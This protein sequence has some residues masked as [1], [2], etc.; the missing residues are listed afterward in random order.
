MIPQ[1]LF[2]T[3]DH[4]TERDRTGLGTVTVT[5]IPSTVPRSG[6]H[7]NL[8]DLVEKWASCYWASRRIARIGNCLGSSIGTGSILGSA[9][10]NVGSNFSWARMK[11][12]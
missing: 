8:I 7:P 4:I 11:I 10:P 9:R 5:I 6:R 12:W 2:Y 3:Q 1:P